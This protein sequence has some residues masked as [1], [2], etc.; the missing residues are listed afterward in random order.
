VP[1]AGAGPPPGFWEVL[2]LLDRAS[3]LGILGGVVLLLAGIRM[4][5]PLGLFWNPPSVLIVLGGTIASVM[6]SYRLSDVVRAFSVLRRAFVNRQEPLPELVRYLVGVAER[7]RREGF[8]VLSEEAARAR[9]P[10]LS[11]ALKLAADGFDSSYVRDVLAMEILYLRDRHRVGQGIFEM[12]GAVAPAFGMAGTLIGLIQMLPK[13]RTPEEMGPN[14][15]VALVTTFYGV[16]LANLFFLPVA[17]KLRLRSQEEIVARE[18]VLEGVLS[19][20]SEEHPRVMEQKL[21]AVLRRGGERRE[22]VAGR[23]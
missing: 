3:I 14:L 21:S 17:G 8:S 7:V 22:A 19:I 5:G 15:A 12:A 18:V 20:L 9:D 16:V 23:G 10:Y 2:P 1:G 4:G 11:R 13:M 6:V